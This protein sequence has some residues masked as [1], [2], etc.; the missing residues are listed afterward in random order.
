MKKHLILAALLCTSVYSVSAAEAAA[1]K[2]P[3][4]VAADSLVFA[5]DFDDT[6]DAVKSVGRAA[7]AE[8]RGVKVFEEGISGKAV[9]L[10]EKAGCPL[11]YTKDT[12]DFDKPGSV[13]IW[14]KGDNWHGQKS[15]RGVGLWGLGNAGGVIMIQTASGKDG[16]C[17]C[18]Q[19]LE[20]YLL[21]SK[22]RKNV[23]YIIP[24]PALTKLCQ[25]WH[26]VSIA[27]DKEY[28]YLSYDG[29]AYKANKLQ[30]PLS[31]AEFAHCNRFAIGSNYG[32][33]FLVDNFRIYGK[34]LSDA[35]LLQIWEN[36]LKLI[37]DK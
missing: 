25:G 4:E 35:E 7:A 8:F 22:V 12:L 26:M 17:P 5:V 2:A 15:G 28:I 9:R 16:T 30:T 37:D 27:W 31:N 3:A 20:L 18:R 14:F 13:I 36:G 33:N 32:K 10:G 21:H 24:A 23:R 19:P 6:T 29:K 34:K 1:A 11:Y